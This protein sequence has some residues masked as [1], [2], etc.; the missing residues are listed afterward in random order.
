MM[1][2]RAQP[3]TRFAR[4]G[5]ALRVARELSGISLRNLAQAAKIGASQLSRYETGK[6]VPKLDSLEKVLGV[7]E[8]APLDFFYLVHVLE[9][10]ASDQRALTAALL[11][12]SPGLLS[13]PEAVRFQS[14]FQQVL[15]LYGAMVAERVLRN[16][17]S[18]ERKDIEHG[19]NQD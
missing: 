1:N 5:P 7:L 18:S 2:E 12:G 10:P 16:G 15:D 3:R 9:N 8:L 11:H 13:P 14:L 4:L 17:V 19:G 6:E